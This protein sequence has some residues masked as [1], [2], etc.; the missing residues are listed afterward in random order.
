MSGQSQSDLGPSD[1]LYS[2]RPTTG[3][4]VRVQARAEHWGAMESTLTL[5]FSNSSK[6]T[7][8]VLTSPTRSVASKPIC[9]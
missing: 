1:R 8:P 5:E 7:V 4:S 6:I 3:G 2:L 9:C